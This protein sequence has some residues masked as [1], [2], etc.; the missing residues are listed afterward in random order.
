MPFALL[1][2]GAVLLVAAVRGKTDGP[3]GLFALVSGDFSGPG[4]FIY[5]MVAILIIGAIGYI[6]K[7]KPVSVAFLGLLILVL[8]LAKGDPARAGGGFFEKFTQGLQSTTKPPATAA[9]SSGG[10]GAAQQQAQA[11]SPLTNAVGSLADT[12]NTLGSDV[13]GWVH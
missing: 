2:I 1:I 4:S 7:V 12:L 10:A 3:D 13:S 8:F 5:W 6:P 9:A 11:L